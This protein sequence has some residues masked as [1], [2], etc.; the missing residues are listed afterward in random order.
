VQTESTHGEGPDC[1]GY[2]FKAWALKSDGSRGRRRWGHFN[3]WHG[4][5]ASTHF[6][7]P[8]GGHPFKTIEKSQLQVLDATARNGH[9]AIVWNTSNSRNNWLYAEARCESCGTGKFYQD[10]ASDENTAYKGVKRRDWSGEAC[11]EPLGCIM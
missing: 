4:P 1:S 11:D 10:Y 9:I 7:S 3:Y 5:F 2:V 6:H 8:S